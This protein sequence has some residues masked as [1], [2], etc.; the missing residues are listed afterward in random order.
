MDISGS[1]AHR[2]G[3]LTEALGHPGADLARSVRELADSLRLTVPSWLGLTMTL[4]P[5]GLPLTLTVLDDGV[6]PGPVA[7]SVRVPLTGPGAAGPGD[8]VVFYA[9]APGAFVD[10]AADLV[11]AL[12]LEPADVALDRHR[13]PPAG[14]PGLGGPAADPGPDQ[15]IGILVDRGR[16][17]EEARAELRRLARHART[18]RS[19]A[20]RQ[21]IRSTARQPR[22]GAG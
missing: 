19:A 7:S 13:T 16:T 10:F 15:A 21:L 2:L 3:T 12:G 1:L 11:F 14:P 22:P 9:D 4:V 17:P 5:D 18:G 8:A 20:A 6:P